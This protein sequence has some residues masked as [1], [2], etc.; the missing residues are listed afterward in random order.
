MRKLYKL[1]FLCLMLLASWADQTAAQKVR[2][3]TFNV[4]LYGEGPGEV[5]QRLAAAT[6]PQAS[7][8]A[9]II[10]RVQPDVLL[11]NE[12]DFDQQGTLVA[13]FENNYL[14]VG[15]DFSESAEGPAP[16]LRFPYR[17][18]APSNTGIHSGADLDRNGRTDA[19]LGSQ[20]YGGDCWGFG[21]YPGQYAMVLLSR[22]P[23]VH[24]QV[25]TFRTFLWKDM[26][27][28]RLPDDSATERGA[29]WYSD[30]VLREFPLS[31]K[32][33]W[34]VPIQV[35]HQVVHVLVSH[36]TPPTYD[37]PED[38]NGR[39]NHDE[40]RFWVDYVAGG[41]EA[42]Y[43]Y[44]DAGGR[45]GL[46]SGARFVIM[47][48]LNGDPHD[49]DGREGISQLLAS[50][51]LADC[52]P[53]QSEGALQQS[54]LQKGANST[55]QGDPRYD[56]L[57]AA[58][59]PGPGNLRLDYVLPASGLKCVASGV[60]WPKNDD[61]QFHLVGTHPFPSSDHRLVWVDV[62]LPAETDR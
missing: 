26:P 7:A 9:E 51:R 3:A 27:G 59:D 50:P 12:V 31:S 21:R 8:L 60:F 35:G 28:A 36:P 2:F 43:I 42:A 22:F 30:E 23:I 52:P 17:Y 18:L 20:D 29:D 47:G 33:H 57:D 5:S 58:D 49:G 37:G 62:L 32:S 4:S 48:D 25:R 39:R 14:A 44:D 46:P 13:T 11:L 19:T 24:S 56:T 10:Q 54:K 6:D 15:Q 53:P 38:R 61:K 34:D 45:G 1:A 55:H 16:P 40:I 41:E